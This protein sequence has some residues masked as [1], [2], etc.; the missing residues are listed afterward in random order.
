MSKDASDLIIRKFINLCCRPIFSYIYSLVIARNVW[1]FLSL[2]HI[3]TYHL[4]E[5]LI[6]FKMSLESFLN[7]FYKKKKVTCLKESPFTKSAA[8]LIACYCKTIN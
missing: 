8:P 7:S 1:F 2:S 5:H 4:K 6:S 3:H